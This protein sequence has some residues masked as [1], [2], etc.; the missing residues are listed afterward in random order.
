MDPESLGNTTSNAPRKVCFDAHPS[1]KSEKT[2]TIDVDA[3]AQELLRR[4]NEASGK[5]KPKVEKKGKCFFPV[6]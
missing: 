2:E 6:L 5:V 3:Q 4:F 1:S